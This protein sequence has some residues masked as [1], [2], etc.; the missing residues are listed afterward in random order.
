VKKA[1]ANEQQQKYH[2]CAQSRPETDAPKWEFEQI[3][4][5]VGNRGS[6]VESNFYAKLQ[7]RLDVQERKKDKLFAD[8]VTQVCCHMQ[9]AR[10]G[11]C[12]LPP[13]GARRCEANH[14]GIE[15]EHRA[16][17]ACVRRQKEE[18]TSKLGPVER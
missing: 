18:H 12:V 9:S 15:G 14:R 4:F 17:C 5:V 2:R 1:E 6:V 3:N 11:D 10:S 13:V 16:Q 7:R 8:P